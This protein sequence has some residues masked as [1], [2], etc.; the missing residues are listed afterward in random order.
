MTHVSKSKKS[1][2][3]IELVLVIIIMGILYSF[4]GN[5]LFSKEKSITI[6][7]NNL[8]EIAR[9]L[10]KTPLEFIIFGRDC[11]K[12]MW[13]Y[14]KEESFNVEYEIFINAKDLKAYKFNNYGE[15]YDFEFDKR[16]IDNRDEDICFQFE[17][18][19]NYSNSSYILEDEE[20]DI[21][22]LFRPYFQSVETFES[23]EDAKDSY[24]SEDLN[25]HSL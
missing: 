21:F 5:N 19:K 23:L 12:S 14:N 4:I 24:I 22:Y 11:K 25:P 9:T 7:L 1:F 13:I 8:P 16:K 10:Q 2:T 20:K 17:I 18:F 3:L 6:K 15:L